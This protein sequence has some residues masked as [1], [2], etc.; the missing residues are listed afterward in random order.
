MKNDI[1]GYLNVP[2]VETTYSYWEYTIRE[3]MLEEF[4]C[5]TV[6]EFLE[7]VKGCKIHLNDHIDPSNYEDVDSEVE[8]IDQ[9]ASEW[10]PN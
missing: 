3:G 2:V 5:E 10:F 7:K 8:R 9:D 6:E 4:G 1:I